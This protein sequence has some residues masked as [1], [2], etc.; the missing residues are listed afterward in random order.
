VLTASWDHTARL[1]DAA[2]G[3]ELVVLRGHEAIIWSAV[4]GRSGAQV[5]TASEDRTARLWDAANGAE[6]VGCVAMR[7]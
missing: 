4:F 7:P 1:W 5:L 3:A 2:N 6:L